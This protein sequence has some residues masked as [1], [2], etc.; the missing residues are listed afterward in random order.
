M[1]MVLND[2]KMLT[3]SRSKYANQL[4]EAEELR[5]EI[6]AEA[7]L[8]LDSF[9]IDEYDDVANFDVFD[10]GDVELLTSIKILERW[11]EVA[12]SGR[13]SEEKRPEHRALLQLLPLAF[14]AMGAAE[15]SSDDAL[16]ISMQMLRYEQTMTPHIARY[17]I[18]SNDEAGVLRAFTNLLQRNVYL[19]GWQ[20]WW[21]QQPLARIPSFS[22]GRGGPRRRQWASDAFARADRSPVLR[23]QAAMTLARHRLTD[24]D[25]LLH[26][27][28]RSTPV[29]RSVVVAAIALLGPPA[30]VK[31]A[32]TSDSQLDRWVFDWARKNA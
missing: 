24:V 11:S 14:A 28:D 20:T 30:S 4:Q 7:E 2:S 32:V 19:T 21:L 5:T 18:S 31:R 27:Y 10:S 9:E 16:A 3:W 13:I 1:G 23:A 17:L 25:Q 26:V 15:S 6:A 22:K 29:V 8:D 12:S